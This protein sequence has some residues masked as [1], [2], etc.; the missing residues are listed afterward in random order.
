MMGRMMPDKNCASQPDWQ[1]WSFTMSNS[2]TARGARR[3]AWMMFCPEKL[4]STM[5]FAWPKNACC[6]RK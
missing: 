1:S 2:A 5:P 6:R 4:S 3:N